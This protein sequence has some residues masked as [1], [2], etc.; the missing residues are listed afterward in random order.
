DE[1]LDRIETVD[2]LEVLAARKV[3]TKGEA[4]AISE[5]KTVGQ[6]EGPAAPVLRGDARS[7]FTIAHDEARRGRN[8]E[9]RIYLARALGRDFEA[10]LLQ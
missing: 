10:A 2:L 6:N 5:R 8:E 3:I 4:E 9:C 1:V 7:Y